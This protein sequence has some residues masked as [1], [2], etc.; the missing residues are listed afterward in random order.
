MG[1]VG[2]CVKT[3]GPWGLTDRVCCLGKRVAKSFSGSPAVGLDEVQGGAGQRDKGWTCRVL[4]P[5]R[6]GLC[7]PVG[8]SALVVPPSLLPAL[9]RKQAGVDGMQA[10]RGGVGG[11]GLSSLLIDVEQVG[12]L[13]MWSFDLQQQLSTG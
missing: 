6:D 5:T 3:M 13:V 11:R 1:C 8:A 2:E 12:P 4:P 10:S 9:P 7:P